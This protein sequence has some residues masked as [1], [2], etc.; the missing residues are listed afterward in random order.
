MRV[1]TIIVLQNRQFDIYLFLCL[2]F[3]NAYFL[4]YYDTYTHDDFGRAACRGLF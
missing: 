3:K 2:L 4:Y 1:G